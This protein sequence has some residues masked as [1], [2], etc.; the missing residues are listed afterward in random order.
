MRATASAI[1][2]GCLTLATVAVGKGGAITTE[3]IMPGLLMLSNGWGMIFNLLTF[4]VGCGNEAF[5]LNYTDDSKE[6]DRPMSPYL[7]TMIMT[8]F[9]ITGAALLATATG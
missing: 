3:W 1:I 5:I 9:W 7:T 2:S 6:P 4:A 8:L